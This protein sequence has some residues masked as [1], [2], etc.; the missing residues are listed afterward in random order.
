M[1]IAIFYAVRFADNML[2]I[3]VIREFSK[4]VVT[5]LQNCH[6]LYHCSSTFLFLS[7]EF[8]LI[9]MFNLSSLLDFILNNA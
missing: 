2:D 3:Y 7:D 1:D 4:R 5:Y 6:I 8:T 9:K